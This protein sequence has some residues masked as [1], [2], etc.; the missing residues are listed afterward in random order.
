M[1]MNSRDWI[2]V[3]GKAFSGKT[4]W[5]KKHL[6]KVPQERLAILD[7][8]SNDYQEYAKPGSKAGV[9]NV[10]TGLMPE[11]E[12]FIST[13]YRHGNCT[14]VLSESD[15]YLTSQTPLMRQFVTTGRNRGINAI[16]DGKRP[17]SVPPN[18]RTRFN[19]LVLF[20]TSAPED[21]D[22]LEKWVGCEKGHLAE[23]GVPTLKLGEHIIVNLDT[24]EISGIKKL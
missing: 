15:N 14:V 4:Y 8:N 1:K 2:F 21:L 24:H 16:V 23:L 11:I 5:I 7:Y 3:T 13:V 19:Y 20:Q 10:H 18:Y 12:K 22:Y 17:K 9:W 6:E